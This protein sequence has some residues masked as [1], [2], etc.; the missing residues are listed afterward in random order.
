MMRPGAYMT[1]LPASRT[2]GSR[3]VH[4]CVATSSTGVAI[5]A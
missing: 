4:V 1:A 3:V 5:A 2:V